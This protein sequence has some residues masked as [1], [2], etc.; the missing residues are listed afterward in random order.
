MKVSIIIAT[1][2]KNKYLPNAL[3]SLSRQKTS[4]PLE[5]CILD[6][7][8]DVD[9]EPI[10]RQ[11]LPD[12]TYKRLDKN[13][14]FMFSQGKCLE[15]ASPDS[16]VILIQS[17]DIIHTQEN[18]VE[19]LCNAV[20][21]RGPSLAEVVDISVPVDL[22]EDF[23]NGVKPILSNWGRYIKQEVMDIDGINYNISTRYSGKGTGSS[24]FFCGAMSREDL[25][26][27]EFTKINC[28][29][30]IGPKLKDKRNN[31][32]INYP[33]VRAIHQ[34]HPKSVYHCPI[35]S[36]CTYNCIRKTNHNKLRRK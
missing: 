9:P 7:H 1:W 30:I 29:A 23:D 28:D 6:D 34:R 16:D 18:S 17:D 4:F 32:V 3:Y 33:P 26:F 24:L 19:L 21:H 14:G 36:T 31:F 5:V 25:E 8:S 22:F 10:I 12:V 15:L 27:L 11:F 20:V 13:V 2:N 35:V